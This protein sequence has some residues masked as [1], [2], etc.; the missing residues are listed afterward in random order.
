MIDGAESAL[1]IGAPQGDQDARH[2][3]ATRYLCI[4]AELDATFALNVLGELFS[5]RSRSVAPSYGIDVVP[6][7]K[8]CVKGRRRRAIRDLALLVPLLVEFIIFPVPTLVLIAVAWLVYRARQ[9]ASA[10]GRAATVVLLG[11]A[12][13][14]VFWLLSGQAAPAF[15]T[16]WS[17]LDRL[18]PFLVSLVLVPLAVIAIGWS[19]WLVARL[20][21]G[22]RL[23]PSTFD[24]NRVDVSLPSW[25]ANRL[26]ALAVQQYGNVTTYHMENSRGEVPFVGS[27]AVGRRWSLALNLSR[28]PEDPLG[29][30]AEAQPF[31]PHELHR[32]IEGRLRAPAAEGGRPFEVQIA[33]RAFV[34]GWYRT[35]VASTPPFPF[36]TIGP[37][38]MEGVMDGPPGPMRHFKCLRA[39]WQGREQVATLFLHLGKEGSTLF[40]ELIPC[41]MTPIHGWYK[42]YDAFPYPSIGAAWRELLRLA[43]QVPGLLFGAPARL[44]RAYWRLSVDRALYER[45][46][47]RARVGAHLMDYGARTSVRELGSPQ[48]PSGRLQVF[49]PDGYVITPRRYMQLLDAD[50]YAKSI[51]VQVLDAIRDFLAAHG[52]DTR[53]FCA[54]RATVLDS[55]VFAAQVQGDV[56][57]LGEQ[58]PPKR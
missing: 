44:S 24:P 38:Q 57:T 14:A 20:L 30:A 16:S 53:E 23:N 45:N 33:D 49:D 17:G 5:Q 6:I 56:V 25:V 37:R 36:A 52:I 35:E 31:A 21:V 8:H 19:E 55:G 1:E 50:K 34:S 10:G 4:G 40:V 12:V 27:G 11:L 9:Q 51:E 2:S 39:E 46:E 41:L 28:P 29:P 3:D 48:E 26:P 15:A 42:D 7:V 13:A 18:G 32:F 58:Q 43:W 54:R 22:T 47:R